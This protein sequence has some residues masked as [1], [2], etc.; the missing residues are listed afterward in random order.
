MRKTSFGSLLTH[1]RLE[2]EEIIF[3]MSEKLGLSPAYISSIETGRME[4]PDHLIKN[5][6]E[7]YS[8]D[9]NTVHELEHALALLENAIT[10]TSDKLP[11]EY[12]L[13][14]ADQFFKNLKN[15]S[16]DQINQIKNLLETFEKQNKKME[17]KM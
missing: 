8:L 16:D 13:S 1:I 2:H 6:K 14:F 4:V 11:S 10:I 9:A 5:L 3:D 17:A 15:L 12:Q 7:T